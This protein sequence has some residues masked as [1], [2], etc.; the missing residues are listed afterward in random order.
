MT[1]AS[2]APIIAP[3]A[4]PIIEIESG[5]IQGASGS[6][7]DCFKNIPFAA[8]TG[9]SGRF[10]PPLPVAPWQGIRPTV[11]FG[12]RAPQDPNRVDQLKGGDEPPISEDC[13]NLNIWR[14]SGPA[15]GMAVMVYIHGGGFSYGSA[16]HIGHDGGVLARR[17][18]MVVVSINYRL[19]VLGL[20]SH[21]CLRDAD[22]GYDGNWGFLDQIAALQW[23]NRNI[24]QFG[25]DPDN[26]TI[27][28][29]S[30]GGGSV[31]AHCICPTSRPLFRRAVVQSS[32]PLP[33]PRADH[34]AAAEILLAELGVKADLAALQAVDGSRIQAAQAGWTARLQNG[35]T[36]P[37]PMLDGE[38]L[39]YWPSEAMAAGLM[40]GLDLMVSH[41][42]DEA[43]VFAMAMAPDVIPRSD[44]HLQQFLAKVGLDGDAMIP[45]Y[46]AARQAR[47]ESDDAWAIWIAL[48]TDRLIRVPSVNFLA[49]HAQRGNNAWGCMV[50]RECDWSPPVP[51]DRPLGA[52]HVIDLPLMF[53]SHHATPELERLASSAPGADELAETIQ[54]A[55]IAFIHTG[56]PVTAKLSAWQRYDQARRS[57]MQLGPD[58]TAVDDPRG[59]ERQLMTEALA[60]G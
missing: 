18:A 27:V 20:L 59:E 30:A 34:A 16:N 45:A 28:G 26:V 50:T 29:L 47:G 57:T 58:L 32:S 53:G 13:L 55:Y 43:T 6:G 3:T 21:P 49:E 52:C 38:L 7:V 46:R 14:P 11:A 33:T 17:G 12:P 19:G 5:R 2:H 48:Q 37:R 31:A 35:R 42:R 41:T 36:A 54:D 39:P 60:G 56:S 15:S 22:T 44:E 51:G 1:Q 10:R 23:V 40:D 24:A 4:G 25:G 9:G 8:D